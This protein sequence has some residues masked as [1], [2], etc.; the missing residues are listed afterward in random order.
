[1]NFKSQIQEYL[2]HEVEVI[3]RLDV[4]AI[5]SA[6][7]LLLEAYNAE[8]T[9]FIF[10]NGGSSA[11]AS[12]FAGDFN[13]GVSENLEKKFKF[14]CLNDNL[15]TLMAIANDIGFEEIFRSQL[16]GYL[17][18]GDIVIA[19]S[20]SGNSANI[21]NAVLYAKEKGNKVIGITGYGG[22]KL[23][24]MADIQLH[25]PVNSMQIAED[26]HMI[27]DHMMMSI[28]CKMMTGKDHFS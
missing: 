17:K 2:K 8:K 27:F 4:D 18:S 9:I 1:M 6:M 16:K 24:E 26:V 20:G 21:I 25:A 22:G 11:T 5:N 12:H 14:V 15:P 7:N 23:R 3:G 19:I 10:G 13:K 28:F